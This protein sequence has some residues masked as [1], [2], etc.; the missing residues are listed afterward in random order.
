MSD[1]VLL[2]NAN[3]LDVEK[4]VITTNMD[5][6]VDGEKIKA[7]G[8][9]IPTDKEKSA[10]IDCSGKFALPGLFECHAHLAHLRSKNEETKK[11]I[12]EDFGTKE[13]DELET[14][15]LREFVIKGITQ[16]RDVGGPVDILRDF[17]D[18]ISGGEL[19][20]PDLFYAGPML[21]KSPLVWEEQNE[22]LP[23]FTV[24]VNSTQD[25]KNII[26]QISK[27]GASLVKTFN[28]FD[29]DIFEY[30]IEAAK[31]HNLPVTHDP[32]TPF[33]HSI[34]MDTAIDLG[35]RCV[36][37]S[38]GPWQVVLKKDLK[39]E[40]DSLVN[41]DPKD[42]GV[43][44]EKVFKLGVN[45]ISQE[46]LQWLMDKM[47]QNDAYCCTTLHAVKYMRKQQSEES[48][49]AMLEKLKILEEMDRYFTQRMIEA[50]V[51]ILVGQDGLLPQFTFDEMRYLKEAGHSEVEIL[52]GATIYPARW[53]GVEDQL[54]SISP[55]K[56][57]NVV[58]LKENPLE[59][60]EN[61]EATYAVLKGGN[62]VFRE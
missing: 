5:I 31:E 34:P 12:M 26:D 20:G 46:R 42:K 22:E 61:I 15:V 13:A 48:N 1:Q 53:L 10:Q 21:E 3:L 2:K 32:G 51:K 35:I 54:G 4:G 57:A 39:S 49:G 45:S 27:E 47:I 19:L 58:I 6:L 28:K 8:K 14:Q 52:R 9:D 30:L 37:H 33:F 16:V 7:V 41:A 43:L 56:R 25:A 23:G 36:E 29:R 50:N 40:H 24:A 60:I 18:R 62:I 55:G 11:Q 38:K 17:K 59:D 44:R